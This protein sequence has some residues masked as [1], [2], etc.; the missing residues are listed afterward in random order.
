[1]VN[2]NLIIL[3]FS[4]Y[5]NKVKLIMINKNLLQRQQL[6]SV[7]PLDQSYLLNTLVR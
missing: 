4:C 1:M 7:I 5:T 6:N 3:S 2:I